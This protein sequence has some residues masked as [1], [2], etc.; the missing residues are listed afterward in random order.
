MRVGV[1]AF[2]FALA[3]A[4]PAAAQT[5]ITLNADPAPII[6][7][8]INGRPVRLEVDLRF[9]RGLAMS[10]AAAERLRVQR[11]PLLGI[12][13]GLEGSNA[14]LRGRLARPRIVFPS[15]AEMDTE[16]TRAFAGIF[17]APVSTRADGVIG[18]GALPYDVVTIVLGP[19]PTNARDIVF[20]LEDADVWTPEAEVGG[21]RVRIMFGLG[22]RA[23]IFNRTASRHY[24]DTG[25][26]VSS[27]ELAETPT[28]LGLRTLMQ[29]VQTELTV[30]GLP[31]A[32]AFARTNAPLL[33]AIEED[34]I[35]VNAETEERPPAIML[36]RASLAGCSL[37]RV[38]RRARRMTLRCAA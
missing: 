2:L 4:L 5:S 22:D 19:E 25:A 17:P 16:S 30:E 6:E 36:G 26:I 18:P 12:T 11:V 21:E 35:V 24:D 10:R 8:Q 20:T 31:I 3:C 13:I 33:G 9:P 29:P 7:A 23:S 15:G 34:A 38:E 14:S 28:I 37:L 27:G 32:P 1:F